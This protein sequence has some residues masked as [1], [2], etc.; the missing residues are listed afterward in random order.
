MAGP[1]KYSARAIVPVTAN[2]LL[3]TCG[4]SEQADDFTWC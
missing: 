1:S 4:D 3:V 2:I